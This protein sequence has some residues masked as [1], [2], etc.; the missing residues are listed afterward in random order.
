MVIR[1]HVPVERP[2]VMQPRSDQGR[3]GL[4]V[5]RNF[6]EHRPFSPTNATRE[7]AAAERESVHRLETF[8]CYDLRVS[9]SSIPV[10]HQY[11]TTKTKIFA[12]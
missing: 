10:K 7:S 8:E 1:V 3:I 2:Q 11:Q 6:A 12:Q 9:W 5:V 4:A